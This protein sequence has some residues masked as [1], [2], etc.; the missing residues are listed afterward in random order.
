MPTTMEQDIVEIPQLAAQWARVRGRLQQEVGEVEYRTWLRQ[1]T[2]VGIDGD[3][4]AVHLPTRFLRDW[5]RGHYGDRIGA[6]WQA[7]NP[8]VRRVDIRYGQRRGRSGIPDVAE[9]LAASRR[10]TTAAMGRG[11]DR[12]G[13]P[14][15]ELNAALDPRFTFD[16]F[17]VGKP[18]E[19]AYACA[20]RVAEQ[21]AS[22][23]LQSAVPVRRRRPGQDAPDARDRLGTDDPRQQGPHIR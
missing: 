16:A 14:R 4:I 12:N 1:M 19:F 13:E 18:N 10:R 15:S 21:P 8:A 2:L 6:L 22:A 5:V 7:E 20:R 17:V 9:S 11:R 3:E 23:G